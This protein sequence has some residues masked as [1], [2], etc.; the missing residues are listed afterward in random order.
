MASTEQP[1]ISA[2]APNERSPI[3]RRPFRFGL[4]GAVVGR[5]VTVAVLIALPSVGGGPA[6]RIPRGVQA[7]APLWG[8]LGSADLQLVELSVRH[9]LDV[10]GQWRVVEVRKELLTVVDQVVQVRLDESA[11]LRVGLVLVHDHP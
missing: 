4:S 1:A 7:A 5:L 6:A 8:V 9:L 2:M 10:R 11:L 3:V